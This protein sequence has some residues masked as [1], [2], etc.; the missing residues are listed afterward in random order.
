MLAG[1][2]IIGVGVLDALLGLVVF[3]LFTTAVLAL[4]GH[5]ARALRLT[6]P[7][8]FCINC[9]VGVAAFIL[10]P[11]AALLFYGAAM[12]VAAARGYAGCEL[13]AMS[14]WLRGRDDEIACCVMA[15]I[16]RAERKAHAHSASMP[17]H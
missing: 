8:G 9:A 4:R 3:P 2:V 12:L 16:D 13:F 5:D 14:N 15:P 17:Q 10:L 11:V 7:E 1:A 6:G